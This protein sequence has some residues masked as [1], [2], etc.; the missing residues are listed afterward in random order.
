MG[1]GTPVP[2]AAGSL[3]IADLHLAVDEEAAVGPF[4]EWLAG[5][6]GVPTLAI[7]GDLFDYWFGMAQARHPA[8]SRV[9]AALAGLVGSGTRI[10]VVLGNRDFLLDERFERITGCRIH[11]EGFQATLPAGSRALFLHGDELCTRDHRYQ[12]MRRV[13]RSGPVRWVAPRLPGLASLAARRLRGVSR[14]EVARKPSEEVLQQPEAAREAARAAGAAL[15]VCGHAHRYRDVDLGSARWIVL[16]AFGGPRSVL[17]VTAGDGLE[18]SDR[19][20][21]TESGDPRG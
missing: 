12:R 16:D 15:L 20:A 13:L 14:R 5:L 19:P 8:T 18:V 11:P 21:P 2:L 10:E 9:L 1:D 7:L 3:V 4:V 17:E 6:E